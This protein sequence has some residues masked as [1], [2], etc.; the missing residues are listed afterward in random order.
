MF[1]HVVENTCRKNVTFGPFHHVYENTGTYMDSSTM[2]M[3]TKEKAFGRGNDKESPR[4]RDT[5]AT[6]MSRREGLA[7]HSSVARAPRLMLPRQCMQLVDSAPNPFMR[8]IF[9]MVTRTRPPSRCC[10][11]GQT[12]LPFLTPKLS[13]LFSSTSWK[14]AC[15][16]LCFHIYRGKALI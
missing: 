11:P 13:L 1:H 15:K 9:R 14:T 2:F 6:S 5:R 8:P 4:R 3:K 16:Y 7:P 10:P 12:Q